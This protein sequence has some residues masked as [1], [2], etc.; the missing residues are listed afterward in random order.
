MELNETA[1]SCPKWV[2]LFLSGIG[3]ASLAMTHLFW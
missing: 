3:L 1:R 2:P